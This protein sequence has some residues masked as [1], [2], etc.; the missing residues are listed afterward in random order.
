MPKPNSKLEQE[1]RHLGRVLGEKPSTAY[2]LKKNGKSYK[3]IAKRLGVS[4]NRVYQLLCMA[5]DEIAYIGKPLSRLSPRYR[6][7]LIAAGFNSDAKILEG[8]TSGAAHYAT[9]KGIKGF[10]H[11]GWK[12]ACDRYGVK[13]TNLHGGRKVGQK[14]IDKCIGILERNGYTVK[15]NGPAASPGQLWPIPS[16]SA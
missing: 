9:S 7:A 10:S 8:L 5:Y 12:Q 15:K 3:H 13:P 11:V 1:V 16:K 2:I 6:K 4:E 14:T